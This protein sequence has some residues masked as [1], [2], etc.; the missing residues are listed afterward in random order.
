MWFTHNHPTRDEKRR[1]ERKAAEKLGTGGRDENKNNVI[2]VNKNIY[3]HQ[4]GFV[5]SWSEKGGRKTNEKYK[6][7]KRVCA[8]SQYFRTHYISRQEVA[9][10]F[11]RALEN[12]QPK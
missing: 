6:V 3:T 4:M 2:I 11:S 1:R 5:G 12:N 10:E 7:L 8:K 9:K